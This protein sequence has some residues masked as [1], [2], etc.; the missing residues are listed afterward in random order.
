MTY[1][2]SSGTLNPTHSLS[3]CC[4]MSFYA[5]IC[6]D[7]SSAYKYTLY[8]ERYY[9]VEVKRNMKADANISFIGHINEYYQ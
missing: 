2:V 8:S 1:C 3:H 4:A 7:C 6:V 9:N 5:C